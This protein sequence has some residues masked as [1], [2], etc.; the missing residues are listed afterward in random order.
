MTSSCINIKIFL[1]LKQYKST[2]GFLTRIIHKF[3]HRVHRS[4]GENPLKEY[5]EQYFLH[6]EYFYFLN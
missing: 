6:N 4:H 5:I 3:H 1:S 2:C